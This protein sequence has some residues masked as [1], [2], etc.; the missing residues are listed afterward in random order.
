MG[1][2]KHFNFNWRV[3]F[4]APNIIDYL[5]FV[6]LYVGFQQYLIDGDGF[7]FSKYYVASY[8]LDAIDGIV[9]RYMNQCSKLGIYLDMVA[10]RISSSLMLHIVAQRIISKQPVLAYCLYFILVSVEIVSH[11][12]V[13]YQSE[14]GGFHQKE[15]ESQS[16]MVK[17]YL[18]N[19][20][21]LFM[22]CA[23]FEFALIAV[24]AELPRWVLYLCLPGF[25]FRC[26]A[27]LRRLLDVTIL[28]PSLQS[29]K[30]HTN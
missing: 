9:A 16:T 18:G 7:E 4:W 8:G 5:R 14:L 17:L 2:R 19:K 1:E 24:L 27:N 21:I 29:E 23:T 28:R 10:D 22:S 3:L 6:L 15:M 12:V 26:L 11:S 25:V 13:M 20:A 30:L